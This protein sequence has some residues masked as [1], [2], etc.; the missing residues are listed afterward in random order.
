MPRRAK[1]VA[2]SWMTPVSS[3]LTGQPGPHPP[4]AP[5]LPTTSV[6]PYL[7]LPTAQPTTG[8]SCFIGQPGPH[9]LPAPALPTTSVNP[10][11]P[12]PTMGG[13]APVN[14][15]SQMPSPPSQPINMPPTLSPHPSPNNNTGQPFQGTGGVLDPLSQAIIFVNTN[16]YIIGCFMLVLNLGGRFLSLELTKK[17]EEF[18]AAPWIRPALFFTVIFIATRNIAAAFWVSL[19]FFSIIWVIANE[20]SPYCL[21]PSWCGHDI[22]KEKKTYEENAK[23]FFTLKHA[24]APEPKPNPKPRFQ[25]RRS[26]R[27]SKKFNSFNNI[28]QIEE[29]FTH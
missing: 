27:R 23:K 19:L 16:P 17:Q 7:P 13:M 3:C 6:N 11:L 5:A 20:H 8:G 25:K 4:P 21:I 29:L 1:K 18:L 22:Q 24:S 15:P 10:Y 28:E 9:P 12:P 26:R 14:I 2:G